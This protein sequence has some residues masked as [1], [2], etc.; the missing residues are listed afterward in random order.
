MARNGTDKAF[1]NFDVSQTAGDGITRGQHNIPAYK[2]P[3]CQMLASLGRGDDL[4]RATD[5]FR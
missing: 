1:L 5:L 4:S 2:S 3:F